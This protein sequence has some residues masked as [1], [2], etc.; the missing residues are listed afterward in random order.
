MNF[1]K[2]IER[3]IAKKEQRCLCFISLFNEYICIISKTFIL[4]GCNSVRAIY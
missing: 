3:V 2:T 1:L 4:N